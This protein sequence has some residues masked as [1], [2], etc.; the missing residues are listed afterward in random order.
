MLADVIKKRKSI[1]SFNKENVLLDN[2]LEIID[3]AKYA[4]SG[5]NRQP[6]K[7]K[8][9]EDTNT[10]EKILLNSLSQFEKTGSLE[11]SLNA[12]KECDKLLLIFNPYSYKEEKYTK[13]NLLMDTQ[14]IGAFIQNIILLL[15]EKGI[16]TLWIND[17]YYSKQEIE[18]HYSSGEM[19][20]IAAI[21]VGYSSKE[22]LFNIRKSI[23]EIIF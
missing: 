17:I 22:R 1:R 15:T 14:S 19:E 12:I 13:K 8:I 23:E 10:I 6:W 16:S 3:I 9:L 4:P 7:I 18:C 20:I 21:A 2:I 11:I 5:K